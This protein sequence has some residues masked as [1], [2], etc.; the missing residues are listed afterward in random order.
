MKS[1][2]CA[3]A[4]SFGVRILGAAA[5]A[6][7]LGAS[8][9]V[10]GASASSYFSVTP[11]RVFDTR[12][13]TGPLGG[14]SI[15]PDEV[16]LFTIAGN[17][18][19]PLTASAVGANLVVTDTT[20][21]GFL[22][23]FPSDLTEPGTSTISFSAT[24]T[25]AG[26]GLF[27]LA[28]D[29]SG[30]LA[31]HNVSPGKIDVVF[32]V[33]GFFDTT[34]S[35]VVVNPTS[36]ATVP[37]GTPVN[38]T[39][40]ASGGNGPYSFSVT[41]GAPPPGVTLSKGGVLSGTATAG[42]SFNFTA[43]ATDI[44]DC[45]GSR[46]YTLLIVCPTITVSP[47]TLPPGAVGVPYGPINF[48]QTGAVGG[49]TWSFTGSLPTGVTLSAAGVLSG[50]PT[51]GGTFPITVKATD[52]GGCFGTVAVTLSTCP[53]LT[54][55]NPG[56]S[57]G[58]AGTAF[59]QMFTH[60]G[61]VPPVTFSL[62]TGALPTGLTL[63]AA[64]V[65]SG[66]PTQTGTFPITVKATDANGCTGT[67]A[68][69][70]LVVSC[71]T[72]TVTD[73]ATTTGTANTAF[74]QTFTQSGGIGTV[75]FSLA[76]GTLPAGLNLAANGTLSGTPTQTGSF[77]ITVKA[78]DANSCTGTG[79]TYTLAIGPK[80]TAKAYTDVGNTQL[81]GGVVAPVTP[82]VSVVA[83]SSGDTSDTTIT[84]AVTVGPTHGTLTAFNSTGTF[85]Y[86]PNAGNTASDSF[87]YTGTSNGVSATQTATIA[88]NG[89]VWWVDNATASGT[90][91]G[92]SNT[93][94]KTMTAVNGAATNNGDFI[95]VFKGSGTAT[96]AYTMK[97]GQQLIGAGATL[98]VPTVGPLVT[99]AGV[100]ANTPTLGGTVTLA[101]NVTAAGFDMNTDASNGI[102]GTSVS[103][104]T[105]TVRNVATTTGTG[106]TIGGSGN[107]GTFLF[108][109]ISSNGAANG[110]SL[111]NSTGSFTVTGDGASDPADTTRGRTTAKLGGGSLTLGS[112]GTIQGTT[113]SGIVLNNTG[114]V[115]LRNMTIFNPSAGGQVVD[116][117]A[118]GITATS[119]NGLTLDNVYINGFTG[120]SG[121]RGIPS[122]SAP[123][124]TNLVMQHVDI[125]GNGTA[126]G[127]ETN[128][129][130][131]VR[132]DELAGNCGNGTAGC[133]WDNSLFFNS[134]EN[135]FFITQ[136]VT[137]ST[138]ST[139]M[140]I[141]NCEFRDT[142]TFASPANNA[143]GIAAFNNAVTNVTATGS[144][145][146]NVEVGGFQY[147]GNDD[148]S[149][150]VNI[151]NSV[152]ENTGS[153]ILL[154][155]GGGS[156]GNSTL[157]FDVSGNTTRQLTGNPASAVAFNF[158]LAGNS[159]ASSLMTGRIVN[160]TIGNPAVVGSG[161]HVGDGID[162]NATGGGTLTATV[163]GNTVRQIQQGEVFFGEANSG[164]AKLNLFV[165]GNTFN[166]D[167]GTSALG[168]DALD[169]TGGAVGTDTSTVCADVAANVLVGD[170]NYTSVVVRA[171]GAATSGVNLAGMSATFDDDTT[172]IANFMGSSGGTTP[173]GVN[174]TATPTPS[175]GFM[176]LGGGHIKG[177]TSCGVTFP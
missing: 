9:T 135:I 51:Q 13:V 65:L 99:I 78:T 145:F 5:V 57:T 46:S 147:N 34:C 50:T 98:N 81:A 33:T 174:T 150:I 52:A 120:N 133:G 64:G 142:T 138:V 117:G 80:L 89:M 63:S 12:R 21:S 172:A 24:Q 10:A 92:R 111:T 175:S 130:W 23:V 125:D 140:T 137:D 109:R 14:P 132:I 146:M 162:V 134:R 121:L 153:D 20:A 49:V 110:I 11:C 173:P 168:L 8:S 75:T 83:V 176:L 36:L 71:Q 77:P 164:S 45:T 37:D 6:C 169:L 79:A 126:A 53:A 170:N 114:V 85:L 15:G 90:N 155:H 38:T 124:I 88:F 152:F 148:A 97:P 66:T 94:F 115:I 131:N 157:T 104:V 61:G 156:G 87:T 17:C 28:T 60:G 40:T 143:F 93:P 25:R 72:I 73:P 119:V 159:G 82:S 29:G 67:G 76:S 32:D 102:A 18:G 118:N 70:P 105:V 19:V 122:G 163:T 69:Y 91:D 35:T 113:G 154:A 116:S 54:V 166:T 160:N 55:T 108:R 68:V 171:F 144:T 59:S 30:T 58:T 141:T 103:G 74:S 136:G 56:T 96:G 41:S 100:D 47:S 39:L 16:R 139:S 44:N 106:V 27:L 149:G 95:Y 7:T 42:G 31:F 112:G 123:S 161:S 127:A 86:T 26:N 128:D 158:F 22:R 129:N 4:S 43:T 151:R 48:M 165:H 101:G 2:A 167:T 177:V 107:S 84:Y 3:H 1:L 62:A